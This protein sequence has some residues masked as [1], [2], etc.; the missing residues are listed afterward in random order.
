MTQAADEILLTIHLKR[1]KDK[2]G[3]FDTAFFPS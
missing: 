3:A 1:Q 2:C